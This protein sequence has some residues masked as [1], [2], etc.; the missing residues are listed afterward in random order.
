MNTSNPI[1]KIVAAV[2]GAV[3]GYAVVS[4]VINKGEHFDQELVKVADTL[5]K[6][7]PMSVDQ[8]TRWDSTLAGPGNR[9]TYIY[10]LVNRTKDGLDVP[11]FIRAIRPGIISGYKT[12]DEMK[13][14]RKHNVNLHYQYKDKN[15]EFVVE[16]VVSPTDF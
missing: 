14:F 10:T 9:F 15:G 7:L 12:S 11:S 16:I 3:I 6:N 2:V 1:I 13:T 5:N 8:E 4:G